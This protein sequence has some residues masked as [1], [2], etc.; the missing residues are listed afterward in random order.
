M[1]PAATP[2]VSILIPCFNAERW[3]KQAI[4]SALEQSYP[5]TEV[6]V[7]DDGSEDGSLEIIKGFSEKIRWEARS[8]AISIRSST[9]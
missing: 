6:I 9:R 4:E 3:I 8:L 1:D 5:N 2:L 7:I